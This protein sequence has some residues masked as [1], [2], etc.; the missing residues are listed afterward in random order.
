MYTLAVTTMF[1]AH[2]AHFVEAYVYINVYV[3]AKTKLCTDGSLYN[4]QSVEVV[5]AASSK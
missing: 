4:T 3:Q 1:H 2:T 5:V